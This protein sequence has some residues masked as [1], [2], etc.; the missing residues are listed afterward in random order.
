MS[1]FVKQFKIKDTD[2]EGI[3]DILDYLD[4]FE[5]VS[6]TYSSDWY[7]CEYSENVFI[8]CETFQEDFP[9]VQILARK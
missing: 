5:T 6:F 7:I 3:R 8:K 4:P 9:N 2:F 1:E